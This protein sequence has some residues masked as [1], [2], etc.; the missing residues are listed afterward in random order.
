[1]KPTS[2]M[3]SATALSVIA[4]AIARGLR[5]SHYCL[6]SIRQPLAATAGSRSGTPAVW[7]VKNLMLM[8]ASPS[9]TVV[10]CI[11]CAVVVW[12]VGPNRPIQ[13]RK[14]IVRAT[15]EMTTTR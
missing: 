15:V 1:M 3:S 11:G 10:R 2:T 6:I 12:R 13:V 9:G 4:L 7:L 14:I 5:S 8:A